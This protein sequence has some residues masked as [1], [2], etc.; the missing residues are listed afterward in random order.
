MAMAWRCLPVTDAHRQ[1]SARQHLRCRQAAVAAWLTGDLLESTCDR[2]CVHNP[3][4]IARSHRGQATEGGIAP[5]L[6]A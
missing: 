6:D 5:E 2:A 3:A 4:R 1:R